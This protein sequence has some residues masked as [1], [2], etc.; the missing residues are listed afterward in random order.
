MIEPD[1]VGVICALPEEID[2][3][4][5]LLSEA[6]SRE[7]AGLSFEHG[8]L[9]DTPVVLAEC[10]IGKVNAAIVSTLLIQ[11]FGC[12]A[13]MM[14]GVAG[15]LDESLRV[16]DIVIADSA[17]QYDYGAMTDQRIKPYP[18]GV[19]PLPGMEAPPAIPM[20][21]SVFSDAKRLSE[22]VDL[23]ELDTAVIGGAVHKPALHFGPVVSGDAFLNC[24][25]TRR[26]LQAE[27]GGLVIEMEG[28]AMAQVAVRFDVPWLIIRAVSDLAGDDSHLDFTAF[29]REAAR[30]TAPLVEALVP[31][32]VED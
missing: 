2:H 8:L 28:A 16:G 23:P 29:G 10:G 3:L 17:L 4:R 15:A 9:A 6:D 14:V 31:S 25:A 18:P 27:T 1:P 26:R 21:P 12:G 22:T 32:L 30:V 13:L 7:L 19:P 11:Q 20:L 24:A 5:P